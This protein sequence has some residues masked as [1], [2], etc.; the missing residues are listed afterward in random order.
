MPIV[1]LRG[2]TELRQKLLQD[3][4]EVLALGFVMLVLKLGA[5]CIHIVNAVIPSL[6][7]FRLIIPCVF[8]TP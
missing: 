7:P 5:V 2:C 8:S 4:F 6:F 1:V 3:S